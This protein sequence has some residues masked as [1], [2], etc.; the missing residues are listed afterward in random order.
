MG[1]FFQEL[2]YILRT[3]ISCLV[4]R[5]E[6]PYQRGVLDLGL[7][8]DHHLEEGFPLWSSGSLQRSNHCSFSPDNIVHLGSDMPAA[9]CHSL[10]EQLDAQNA[11]G[12]WI[13]LLKGGDLHTSHQE[14]FRISDNSIDSL[15]E[16]H[17]TP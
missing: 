13:Q 8:S 10:P 11:G 15:R 5:N 17:P 14:P 9:V 12:Q 4:H 16:S 3:R 6:A 7:P 1:I 2:L